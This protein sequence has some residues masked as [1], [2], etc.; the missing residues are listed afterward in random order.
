MLGIFYFKSNDGRNQSAAHTENHIPTASIDESDVYKHIESRIVNSD[1]PKNYV[2]FGRSEFS[3]YEHATNILINDITDKQ[4]YE[5]FLIYK[6]FNYKENENIRHDVVY[7]WVSKYLVNNGNRDQIVDLLAFS[8]SSFDKHYD[9]YKQIEYILAKRFGNIY[10]MLLSIYDKTN[11]KNVRD[12]V[13]DAF[14]RSKGYDPRD[15]LIM[16]RSDIEDSNTQYTDNMVVNTQYMEI[17][18]ISS[19]FEVT[20]KYFDRDW[21]KNTL[22]LSGK[23]N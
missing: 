6:K 4:A 19:G 3:R 16:K 8:G 21:S 2:T 22:Y 20:K 5:L 13:L 14:Q 1:F 7:D 12:N 11:N 17:M 18:P 9:G 10:G 15:K 23:S